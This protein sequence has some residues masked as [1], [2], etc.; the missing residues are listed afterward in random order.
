MHPRPRRSIFARTPL[1]TPISRHGFLNFLR[2]S[3]QN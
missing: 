3:A 2:G 1:R